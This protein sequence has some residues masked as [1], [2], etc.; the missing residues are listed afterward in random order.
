MGIYTQV[1]LQVV[2]AY[3]SSTVKPIIYGTRNPKNLN[4]SFLS[5]SCFA[6]SIEARCWV[7]NEDVVGAAP[8]VD[9]PTTPEWSPIVLPIKGAAYIRFLTVCRSVN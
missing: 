7:E 6:Q 1:L 4:T 5:C 2:A 3:H 9:D 8:T